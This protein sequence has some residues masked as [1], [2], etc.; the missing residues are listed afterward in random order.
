M[1]LRCESGKKHAELVEPGIVEF[2]CSD[3]Y[4]GA[5]KGVIVLHRF[6]AMTGEMIETIRYKN[7]ERSN[8]NAAR[9][10]SAAVRSA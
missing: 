6:D 2:R 10:S 8:A 4:C 9:H 5:R 1:D 3:R 7:P